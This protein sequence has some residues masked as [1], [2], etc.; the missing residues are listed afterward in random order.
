M[1]HD[2][3]IITVGG[4]LA[5]AALAKAMAER[6]CRVLVVERETRF[7]DRVRG[8]WLAPW[9]VAEAK[10]LGIYEI[11]MQEGGG[12]H[13]VWWDT[14]IGP[15][16]LGDRDLA[17]TT[18]AGCHSL[19]FYHPQMQEALLAAAEK[20]GAEVRRGVRVQAIE[21]GKEPAVQLESNGGSERLTTRLIVGADG[22]GSLVRKWAGSEVSSIEE[23]NQIGG[24][25]FEDTSIPQDRSV[26]VLNPFM[27]RLAIAFP[28][29]GR[30]ARV[31]MANRVDEGVRLQGE[32]DVPRFVEEVTR[33]GFN[34]EY[35]EGAR[36]AGPLATF[37]GVYEWVDAP[38]K[39]GVALVGD[40]ACTSDPTWGQGL[41]LTVRGVRALRDALLGNDDREKAGRAYT[42]DHARF[43][44]TSR[45]VECWFTDLFFSKG[46]EADARRG[47][48]LGL[49]AREPDR[50]HDCGLSGPDAAPADEAARRR[51]FGED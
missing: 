49:V 32:K 33:T 9:G 48:A 45:T 31:Y 36:A 22:R 38:Y 2:Y 17:A 6:G 14:R 44:G 7:K 43:W 18:P 24:V 16:P 3:D 13:P 12:Y 15:A 30:R 21:T 35:L 46:P 34:A 51:F 20:A 8:E 47:R 5:G 23:I 28:Q 40:A 27:Q 10:D 37:A 50:L 26:V 29:G 41:S 25:L 39:D 19:T 4:G 11:L 42:E 1:A